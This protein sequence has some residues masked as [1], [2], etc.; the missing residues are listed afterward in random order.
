MTG[1]D[2]ASKGAHAPASA[3]GHISSWERVL[4]MI[5]ALASGRWNEQEMNYLLFQTVKLNL[6]YET[7]IDHL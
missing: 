3:C 6:T 7:E 2:G 1:H 4:R 5:R